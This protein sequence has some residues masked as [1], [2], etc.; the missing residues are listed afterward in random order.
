MDTAKTHV[1]LAVNGTLMRGLELEPN[2]FAAKAIFQREAK[3]EKAYRL[4][5]INDIHPAM[6][7]VAKEDV[8]AISV[9]LEVWAVP[10]EGLADILLNE[11]AGLSVGK[12]KLDS[13]E[14]V[15]GVLGEPKLVIDMKEISTYNGWRKYI[16]TI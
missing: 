4:W 10:K 15:L 13:G 7:R 2:M 8:N 14:I 5:S 12:V 16:A 9:D 3:T 1:L 11:P 6:I